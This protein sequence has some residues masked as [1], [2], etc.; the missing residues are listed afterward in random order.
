MW[1]QYEM[2]RLRGQ[3]VTSQ[4]LPSVVRNRDYG[5]PVTRHTRRNWLIVSYSLQPGLKRA[6]R[7]GHLTWLEW[8]RILYSPQQCNGH[9][10]TVRDGIQLRISDDM[11]QRQ[12]FIPSPSSPLC[13][14][15]NCGLLLSPEEARGSCD[16]SHV[17]KI[18]TGLSS[19]AIVLLLISSDIRL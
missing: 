3:A 13:W 15:L 14:H 18:H 7:C 11:R 16:P 2:P 4:A 12:Y 6:A 5:H 10:T 17:S 19:L 1:W 9:L 8:T